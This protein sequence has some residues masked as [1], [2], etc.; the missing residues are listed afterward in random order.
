MILKVRLK[1]ARKKTKNTKASKDVKRKDET[2][3]EN[4]EKVIQSIL[5]KQLSDAIFFID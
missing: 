3:K 5:Y 4:I 2:D 1:K